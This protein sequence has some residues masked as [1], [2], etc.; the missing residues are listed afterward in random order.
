VSR[1]H[2]SAIHGRRW[3]YQDFTTD[4]RTLARRLLGRLL[5]R[6]LDDGTVLA[7]RIVETEAYCGVKDA[8]SHAYRGRRTPRNEQMYA[9]PGTAYVYFTYGMHFCMNVVCGRKDEPSAVLI[10]A[11]EP[12]EGIETMRGL[13]AAH[14]GRRPRSARRPADDALCSGP[15]RL[16]QA[17]AIGREQNGLDLALGRTLYIAEPHAD[18]GI[19]PVSARGIVRTARIGIGYAGAW[20][21]KP[22]RYVVAGSPHV[23]KPPRPSEHGRRGK[24]AKRGKLPG[25]ERGHGGTTGKRTGR[26]PQ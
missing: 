4:A 7:G 6:V 3:K 16:C 19:P 18:S 1:V 20:A 22:L 11:V 10:R 26:S 2:P 23:S 14:P 24:L 17:I 25:G 15:A 9:R 12:V 21:D 5:A 8:A 13:R